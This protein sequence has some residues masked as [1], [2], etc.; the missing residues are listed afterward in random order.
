[1]DAGG[2]LDGLPGVVRSAPQGRHTRVFLAPGTR[3]RDLMA[4]L[5]GRGIAVDHFEVMRTPLEEIFVATVRA[6][7]GPG[8]FPPP[9]PAAAV[10]GGAR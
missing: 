1:V 5:A 10:N 8:A 2:P 6:R 3:P 4:A 7:T 9:L